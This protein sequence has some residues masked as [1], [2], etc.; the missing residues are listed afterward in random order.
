MCILIRV[1]IG[2]PAS[3]CI[4]R[5]DHSVIHFRAG[6]HPTNTVGWLHP[7]GMNVSQVGWIEPINSASQKS[8]I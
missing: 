7:S 1:V 2:H 8:D 6:I 4:R 3:S 5:R